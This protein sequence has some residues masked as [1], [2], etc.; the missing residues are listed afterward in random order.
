MTELKAIRAAREMGSATMD[1]THPDLLSVLHQ[2]RSLL[3]M[4][5]NDFTWSSWNDAGVATREIDEL[6]AAV[7]AGVLPK[8]SDVALLFCTHR[9]DARSEHK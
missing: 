1:Q 3:A 9:S 5:G 2:A 8:R 6:I 4:P 7:E